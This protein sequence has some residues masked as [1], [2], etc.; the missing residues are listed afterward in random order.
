MTVCLTMNV[1]SRGMW[2]SCSCVIVLSCTSSLVDDAADEAGSADEEEDEAEEEAGELSGGE[3]V[4][5]DEDVPSVAA[6][7]VVSD[8]GGASFVLG[9]LGSVAPKT[10]GKVTKSSSPTKSTTASTSTS[11][12][13]KV[14]ASNIDYKVL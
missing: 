5:S 2:S 9:L 7:S 11:S 13:N 14:K 4:A 8:D 12:T 3:G 6:A 10:P 1:V